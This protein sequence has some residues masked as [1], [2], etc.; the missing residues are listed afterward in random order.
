MK[1]KL[2]PVAFV[3]LTIALTSG[4]TR[5]SPGHV[6]IVVNQW[7]SEKGVADYSARTGTFTYNPFTTSVFEY[8][9]YVQNYVWTA[10]PNEGKATNE[11]ITF[12]IKGNMAISLDVSIA[13]RLDPVKVP[14]FYVQF[15]SDD[16]SGFTHGFLHNVTRDCFNEEGG[17]FELDQIMGDNATFVLSVRRM[18][19][20]RVGQYGVII[21]QFGIIGAPR[22]PQAVQNAITAKIGATQLAIQKQNELVQAQADAAKTVA[23]AE[24][25]AKSTL[26][27]AETQA[28]SNRLLNDSLTERLVQYRAIDKWN[29]YLPTYMSGGAQLPF[30]VNGQ[31]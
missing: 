6:G 25:D 24:G 14:A 31:K 1:K 4:C 5:I 8:P 2:L 19:E 30:I 13:Y 12:T 18:L 20:S 16:L 7:G 28:K 3:L 29:G 26:I 11:E 15:R 9:T 23:K 27:M 10:N 22:P 17:K 21:E